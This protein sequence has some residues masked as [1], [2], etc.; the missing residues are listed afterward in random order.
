MGLDDEKNIRY[1]VFKKEYNK[2]YVYSISNNIDLL[3]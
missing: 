1:N 3:I 2:I